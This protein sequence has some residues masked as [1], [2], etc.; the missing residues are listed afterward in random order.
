MKLRSPAG[1]TAGLVVS[2][3]FAVPAAAAGPAT[4]NVRVEG[5]QSTIYEG[6]LT[7]DARTI[8][9]GPGPTFGAPYPG[10][11]HL[12]D[13]R[14]GGNPGKY[15]GPGGSPNTALDD[16]S[17]LGAF[18]W[19][20]FFDSGFG[21]F[22]V[23]TIGGEGAIAGPYWDVRT[24]YESNA[25]GGCQIELDNGDEVLFAIDAFGKPGLKLSGPATARPGVPFPVS[26]TDGD[27]DA[28]VPDATV[29]GQVTQPDGRASVQFDTPGPKTLKASKD[30][31]VRSNALNVCV[32]SGTDGA[33]GT[34]QPSAPDRTA[35]VAT[36]AGIR[37]GQAFSRR[38]AP[39]ELR[40]SVTA[41][42]SGLWAVKIRLTRRLGKTCWYFSGSKEQFLKR[43]CGKQ[44]AFKVGD[45]T[46]WSYLLPARLPRGRY[47]LD[48][49][50]IDNVFNHG[51]SQTVRF[52]VR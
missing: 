47:V 2:M 49:Y 52:R 12:C 28:V 11:T 4:V 14:S 31:T 5:A 23:A 8:T 40:G 1:L 36:I 43:T 50:A 33:C 22:F 38:G 20:G 19:Y 51:A 48:S 18:S 3:L 46:D 10:G 13:G 15:A 9:M 27:T 30:G 21:D 42:P 24:E 45:R 37:D 26:V 39:R 35:P 32:T 25:F 44:Y 7:T 17:K 29:G 16:A 34:V 41:D 6:T